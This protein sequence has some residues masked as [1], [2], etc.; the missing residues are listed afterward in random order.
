MTL[1]EPLARVLEALNRAGIP[2]MVVGS[3]A[4][5]HHG[6]PRTTADLDLVIDPDPS[7]LSAFV[8]DVTRAGYYADA[9]AAQRAIAE[10]SQ[11][12]VID[13][14]SGWKVDLMIRRDRPFSVEEFARRIRTDAFGPGGS[15][16]TA[17]DTILAKLE[18]A[19]AS[20]SE[21]QLR[22]VGSILDVSG[23][24]LDV[25]Y[26][27]RWAAELGLTEFWARVRRQPLQPGE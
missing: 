21:R 13:P 11:L 19:L 14:R 15:V 18:W 16:A 4:S 24:E 2:W 17:E 7:A 5:T 26:I 12:N 25:G 10:R 23:A 6:E 8:A 1:P 9:H 3:F 27:D 22:D 20:E